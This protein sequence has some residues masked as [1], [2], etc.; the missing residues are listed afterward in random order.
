MQLVTF[1]LPFCFIKDLGG[2]DEAHSH[3]VWAACFSYSIS[4]KVST[5]KAKNNT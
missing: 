5:L 2:L 1:N 4:L 3:W